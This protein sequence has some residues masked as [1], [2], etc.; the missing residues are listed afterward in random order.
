MSRSERGV[1]STISFMRPY[2][3]SLSK[4]RMPVT[5][6]KRITPSAN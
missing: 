2:I 3:D 6:S 5:H 4:G 1:P